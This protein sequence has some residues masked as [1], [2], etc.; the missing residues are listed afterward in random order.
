MSAPLTLAGYAPSRLAMSAADLD[1]LAGLVEVWQQKRTRNL[2]RS[3]YVAGVQPFVDLGIALPPSLRDKDS[4]LM[5]PETVVRAL[6][7]MIDLEGF[8]AAGQG[9]D[10]FGVSA[11]VDDNRLLDEVPMAARSSAIHGCSFL[12]VSNG[13]TASGEPSQ[14]IL[15]RAADMSAATWDRRRRRIG[16]FLAVTEA[17][18]IGMPTLMTM[19]Q[20]DKVVTL[21][22]RR[23]GSWTVDARRN[24]LG[25]VTAYALPHNPDLERPFGRSRVT[26]ALMR[27][28]DAGIRTT[29]R[30][31][32][33]A[34]VYAGPQYW[35]LGRTAGAV[36]GSDKWK[37][38]YG[39]VFGLSYDEDNAVQ[40]DVKR[41]EGASPQ[42]HIEHL[43][44]WASLVSS[45][46]G[47][48]LSALGV[49]HDQPAS[50]EAIFAERE[51]L[52]T[53]AKAF[54]RSMSPGVLGAVRAAL[55]LRDGLTVDELRPLQAL[56]ADPVTTSPATRAD[57]FVKL[58]TALPGFA[59]T[60]VGMEYAGLTREQIIR[61]RDERRRT[62][63]QEL[64]GGVLDRFRAT[65]P[66]A[67]AEAPAEPAP[68]V[69]PAEV[70][71][72]RL[73]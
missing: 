9:T 39:R 49:V 48:P 40:P 2:L 42:P 20:W 8:V 28:T 6:T 32:L 37:A 47:V 30:G 73:G 44:Q 13:D 46:S 5:W 3:M 26:R 71:D 61:F 10:P 55:R 69:P 68:A 63:G 4:A 35:I 70:N 62:T 25:E 59:D 38:A 52:M 22:R 16:A 67:A 17:D 11:L 34:E 57:A 24:P 53:R 36:V 64:L 21:S 7:D 66:G 50:A 14:L 72:G 33:N 60:E 51:P 45:D 41:F 31:E 12:T 54:S 19:Y 18:E 23:D 56:W 65:R 1:V 29:F 58:S 15:P 43:R 27:Y